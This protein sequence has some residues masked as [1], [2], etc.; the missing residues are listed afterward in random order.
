MILENK[1]MVLM[2]Y[3]SR[4]FITRIFAV[5]I[6]LLA[7]FT[8]H[9]FSQEG[10][11]DISFEISGLFLLTIC[12]MGRLWALM[13]ISGNKRIELINKGPYSIVRNPL[14]FFSLIGAIGFGLASENLLILGLVIIFYLVYYPLTIIAEESK[15]ETTFGDSYREY[16]K[17]TPR[18]IP[19]LSL[20]NSPELYTVK[21]STFALHFIDGMGFVWLFMLF[22]FIEMLQESAYL[23]ILWKVP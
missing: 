23:P 5:L 21:V 15:L 10:F 2:A 14:Y 22:H 4:I 13:Y 12:S 11:L 8:G 16:K 3:N 1:S 9:S 6:V 7:V 20:Y 18:F 19:K 17:I